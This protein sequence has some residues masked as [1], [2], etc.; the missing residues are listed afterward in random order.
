MATLHLS[1]YQSS[2]INESGITNYYY[3]YY[4]YYYFTNEA[5]RLMLYNLLSLRTNRVATSAR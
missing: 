2:T 5:V 4:Y 3:Y 1:S